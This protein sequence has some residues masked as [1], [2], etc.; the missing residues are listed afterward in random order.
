VL[1]LAAEIC[2][3][4][5]SSPNEVVRGRGANAPRRFAA[6]ALRETTMP[7]QREVG[8]ALKM[9]LRQVESVLGRIDMG[10]EPMKGWAR[11]LEERVAGTE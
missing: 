4:R 7:K 10:K 2:G 8:A 6:W 11:V 9:S 3:V 5:R 1:A